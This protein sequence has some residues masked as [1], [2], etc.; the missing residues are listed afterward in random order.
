MFIIFISSVSFCRVCNATLN[1]NQLSDLKCALRNEHST[2][3]P[4]KP[5][6]SH[7]MKYYYGFELH[8]RSPF[9]ESFSWITFPK[10]RYRK[11]TS[12]HTRL[13]KTLT[14]QPDKGMVGLQ[15][16]FRFHNSITFLLKDPYLYTYASMVQRVQ[17]DVGII[18]H[19]TE[20]K[21]HYL[22]VTIVYLNNY[23]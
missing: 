11:Q 20:L 21:F 8:T 14:S 23:I 5:T 13:E 17:H 6:Q 19:S 12:F 15:H 7:N 10:L 18:Q 4:C 3:T 1:F 2:Y 16:F 9:Y 22:H